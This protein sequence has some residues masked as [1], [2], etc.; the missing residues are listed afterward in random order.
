MCNV[1]ER[2]MAEGNLMS[3]RFRITLLQQ[4]ANVKFKLTIFQ[5][6]KWRDKNCAK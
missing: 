5:R 3:E 4:T 1:A 6:R 2:Y